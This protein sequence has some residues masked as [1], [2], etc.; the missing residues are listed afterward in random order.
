MQIMCEIRLWFSGQSGHRFIISGIE[1]ST[2]S[3][4]HSRLQL[5]AGP[6]QCDLPPQSPQ[7]PIVFA[8][9]DEI[10][11]AKPYLNCIDHIA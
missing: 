10:D 9:H 5:R 3:R 8:V 11:I 1:Y 4:V 7:L 2:T 6:I